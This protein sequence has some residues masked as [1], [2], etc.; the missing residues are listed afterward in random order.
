MFWAFRCRSVKLAEPPT[1][2]APERW[3]KHNSG[4]AEQRNGGTAEQ[5]NGGTAEQRNGGTA[6]RRNGGTAERRNGGTAERRNGWFF[7]HLKP[8]EAQ[9]ANQLFLVR[10]TY[11]NT[12]QVCVTKQQNV[13]VLVRPDYA[14]FQEPTRVP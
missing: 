13:V 9:P 7:T 3:I 14:Y 8:S 1:G 10:K 12:Y 5:R 4:I 11:I 2:W 6:E